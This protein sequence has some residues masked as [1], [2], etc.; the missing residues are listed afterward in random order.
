MS[1]LFI[2]PQPEDEP[3]PQSYA[4]EPVRHVQKSCYF[5][6][7]KKYVKRLHFLTRNTTKV[8]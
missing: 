6:H 3:P 7:V 2:Q 4:K 5:V 8:T 1:E